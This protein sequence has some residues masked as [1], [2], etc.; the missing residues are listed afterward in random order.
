M[1]EEFKVKPHGELPGKQ[2]IEYWRGGVFVAGI[3][4]HEDGIRVVSKFLGD[5]KLDPSFPPAA[6]IMLN[7]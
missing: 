7:I 5:V 1:A 3:Y 6:V 2:M 4:P